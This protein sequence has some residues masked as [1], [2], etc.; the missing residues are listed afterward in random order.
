MS[1][2]LQWASGYSKI[3]HNILYKCLEFF[4]IISERELRDIINYKSLDLAP[5]IFSNE[6]FSIH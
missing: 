6:A 2:W 4:L 3:I 1:C 5:Y